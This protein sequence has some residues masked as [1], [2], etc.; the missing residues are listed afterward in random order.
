MAKDKEGHGSEAHREGHKPQVEH[1]KYGKGTEFHAKGWTK[2]Q[3]EQFLHSEGH[4]TNIGQLNPQSKRHLDKLAK[5]GHAYK[6][7]DPYLAGHHST[8]SLVKPL[9]GYSKK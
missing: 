6:S 9:P 2:E 8:W 7:E 5:S 1:G 4:V 3:A